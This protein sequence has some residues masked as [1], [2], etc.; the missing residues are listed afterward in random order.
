MHF[1]ACQDRDE[2][3][4]TDSSMVRGLSLRGTL[5]DVKVGVGRAGSSSRPRRKQGKISSTQWTHSYLSVYSVRLELWRTHFWVRFTKSLLGRYNVR[6]WTECGR[7]QLL[8][9]SEVTTCVPSQVLHPSGKPIN[10][11]KL[12]VAGTKRRFIQ[13][14]HIGNRNKR[15]EPLS[16]QVHL[17]DPE[18]R[19]QSKRRLKGM[20]TWAALVKVW[21]RPP[22]T[23]HCPCF[24]KLQSHPEGDFRSCWNCVKSLCRRQIS[25]WSRALSFSQYEIPGEISNS[26]RFV[27]SIAL[28]IKLR[29]MA[30]ASRNDSQ[31][32]GGLWSPWGSKL[33]ILLIWYLHY[34][35][36]Q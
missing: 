31:H 17:W 8:P 23:H 30:S 10:M 29:D 28:I 14:G 21:P 3:F 11:I 34:D 20:Y 35:S 2:S 22:L 24:S 9:K 15:K 13:S 27:V 25:L 18:V 36:K 19:V 12:I 33:V 6:S 5:T 32:V 1:D 7:A 16:L 4:K 26:L